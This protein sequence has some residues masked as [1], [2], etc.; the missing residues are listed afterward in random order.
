MRDKDIRAAID[1]YFADMDERPSLQNRVL[2]RLKGEEK[3]KKKLSFAAIFAV[4]LTILALT[5]LAATLL[6]EQ[7]VP[8]AKNI[9]REQGD[10]IGWRIGDKARLVQALLDTGHLQ[11]SEDTTLALDEAADESARHARIDALMAKL[12]GWAANEVTVDIITYAVLG[13]EDTW[14]PEQ[15]VWWQEISN[16]SQSPDTLVV[17]GGGEISEADAVAIGRAAV[18]EAYGMAQGALD[19][20]L[21]VANLYVTSERP[22][23]KRWDIQFKFFREDDPS[24]LTRVYSVIVDESGEV[25][26]DPDVGMPHV[27]DMAA[28]TKRLTALE[29]RPAI[30]AFLRFAKEAGSNAI[31]EWS[32][33][34][35]ARFSRELRGDMLAAM[36]SGEL[37]GFAKGALW[38]DLEI[39][40][41]VQYI[42][43]EPGADDVQEDAALALAKDLLL[44]KFGIPARDIKTVYTY[45]DIT[46]PALPRWKFVVE[47]VLPEG[48]MMKDSTMYRV[49]LNG[50]TG[51]VVITEAFPWNIRHESMENMLKWQ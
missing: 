9:E 15:R 49:E 30:Q 43:G 29:E 39:A 33:K 31:L 17:P 48:T 8:E 13:A 42:Y 18:V 50:H 44:S 25:I 35:Q 7:F 10:F 51:E 2:R 24:Y 3:V 38:A 4:C 36:E 47:T 16:T 37:L 6:W 22:D 11:P 40:A 34:D 1:G 19:K 14:S 28:E 46:D 45:Y 21:P 20:A 32:V 26:A 23:Y 27:R 41:S 5:A 12:T